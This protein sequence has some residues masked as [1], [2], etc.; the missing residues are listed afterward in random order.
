M[1]LQTT[2]QMGEV[3]ERTLL[4]EVVEQEGYPNFADEHKP[5]R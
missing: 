2:R 4:V 3:V 5:E 1:D